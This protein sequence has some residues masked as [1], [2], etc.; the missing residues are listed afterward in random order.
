MKGVSLA[1]FLLEA[2]RE[3]KSTDPRDKVFAI[4]GIADPK[5]VDSLGIEVNY[6]QDVITLYTHLA[7]AFIQRDKNFNNFQN[8]GVASNRKELPT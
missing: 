4:L 5:D 7:K 2:Y 8:L 1:L 6:D 3:M